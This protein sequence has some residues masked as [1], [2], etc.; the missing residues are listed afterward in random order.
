MEMHFYVLNVEI[1]HNVRVEDAS[2]YWEVQRLHSVL[3]ALSNFL[4]G[5]VRGVKVRINMLWVVE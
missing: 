1:M 3:I 2:R 4:T 5:I